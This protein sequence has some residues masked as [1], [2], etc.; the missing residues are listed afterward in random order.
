MRDQIETRWRPFAFRRFS[1]VRPPGV[2]MRTR[3]PCRFCRRRFLGWYVRFTLRPPRENLP[4]YSTGYCEPSLWITCAQAPPLST[5]CRVDS[6]THRSTSFTRPPD[7]VR[8][9]GEN[10]WPIRGH[11]QGFAHLWITLKPLIWSAG[12]RRSAWQEHPGPAPNTWPLPWRISTITIA[13]WCPMAFREMGRLARP[14]VG[15]PAI[16][17]NSRNRRARWIHRCARRSRI[18]GRR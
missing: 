3:N 6:F 8:Y 16:V 5:T 17:D 9:P 14:C 1:T 15:I 10:G 7:W 11:P 13:A 12:S 2:R 4:H 18:L